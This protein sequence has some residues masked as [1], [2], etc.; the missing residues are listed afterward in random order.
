MNE[1]NLFGAQCPIPINEYP[2]VLM[3][4]GGGGRLTQM[5]IDRMFVPAFDNPAL[6]ALHDGA[7]LEVG[8]A[9]L[10]FSTDSFV[11]SPIFFPGGDIGSLAVHGTV[12]DLAMCGAR[13]IALSAGLVLEEGLPMD[14]LWRVVK[15]M[16]AAAANAGVSIVTGDTKVVNRGKGDGVYINTSG[17]GLIPDGVR[18][19]PKLARPGDVVL[20]NGAIAVHGIAIMSVREGLEFETT[21]ESDTASLVDLTARVLETAGEQVHTLRDPTRGGLASALNEIAAQAQVGIRLVE[22]NI[23]IWDAVRGACEILGLDPLYVANEGKM[24]VIVAREAAD[25][26]LAAMKDHPLGREAAIIGEVVEEHPGRVFL[27]SRIGGSRVVDMMSGE[28]L[29]RIC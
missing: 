15:S 29:P 28:Q 26:V 13:P 17:I 10:A 4:H 25:A 3:A 7:V 21:L 16:Q 18:V 12:N 14:D 23:P 9:R 27:R 20:I 24:L 11:I 19:S 2:H 5:L 22:A 1:L 6:E 8:G